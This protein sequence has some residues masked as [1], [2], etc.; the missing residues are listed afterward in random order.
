MDCIKI[1]D[2]WKNKIHKW[3]A[4][5]LEEERTSNYNALLEYNKVLAEDNLEALREYCKFSIPLLI[6]IAVV[7]CTVNGLKT[8]NIVPFAVALLGIM[9]I[10]RI[11][12]HDD[13]KISIVP[14]SYILSA[15]FNIIWYVVVICYDVILQP[16]SPAVLSCM[17]FAV[18]ALLYNAHPK[19][20]MIASMLAYC[21][22]LVLDYI[23]VPE[24]IFYFDAGNILIAIVIGNILNHKFTR[25]NLSQKL[26]LDMYRTASKTSI[27]VF[28]IDF[29]HDTYRMLQCP[30]YMISSLAKPLRINQAIEV[31]SAQFIAE[32]FRQDFEQ[33]VDLE[34]VS[35]RLNEQEQLSLYF[36]DFRKHW[37]QLT[38][39]VQKRFEG[40][41]AAIVAIVRDVDEEKRREFEYQRKLKETARAAEL[42]NSAKTNF[43]SR[44]THDIR[45][46]L[47]GIIGLLNI[48]EAHKDDI[49]LV[50]EN[51]KKMLV[52]A[53][54]LLSLINDMLEMSKLEDGNII[55]SHEVINLLELSQDMITIVEQRAVEAN[56]MLESFQ[57]MDDLP[58]Q[59]VYGSPL[60]IR[61]IFLNIY[62][63][64]IKYNKKGGK[65][66]TRFECLGVSD[67]IVTYQW[68]ISD[69]GIGMSREF[70][71]HIFEP[72]SQEH[73]DAR[74]V[75]QGTG[76]G[77]SI[78]KSLI[79]KMN[80]SIKIDSTEGEGSTFVISIPFET[81]QIKDS[82]PGQKS[83]ERTS[84]RGVHLLLAED[85]ELNAEIAET[86][87]RDEGAVVTIVNNGQKVID[88]FK[89]N[90]PGTYDAIL[91]DIMMPEVDGLTATKVIRAM[92]REDA[93]GIP[94][95][96]M[97]ANAFSEDATRCM[98]AGMNA[99][100][101]KPLQMDKV[102]A[103]IAKFR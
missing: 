91:M 100:L 86:L 33:F 61:Q 43:L 73:T 95:I 52:S 82:E 87:L 71:E 102:I 18:L 88:Q 97:T 36:M 84:I 26:Y 1:L 81:A 98:E 13:H 58:Y 51:R 103:T 37:C 8:I 59:Y 19:D 28:Q 62:G 75:Y 6:I 66:S 77:M 16:N 76:L 39:V 14:L 17:V 29:L 20:N 57:S 101:T 21:V 30:D 10:Q 96:A 22:M 42:A 45:T 50:C 47:N 15:L 7:R 2:K 99:H 70:L 12:R 23:R 38:L 48:N 60:H 27:L 55:L 72:F 92:D 41:I 46:P 68:T 56:I 49:Q 64:C 35:D 44:M 74:S 40:K 65:V 31:I 24:D 90:P 11:L 4:L 83:N 53:N 54:Y 78:V 80:G 25:L 85:N 34:T 89:N 32:E 94:I 67:N 5:G 93:P 79:D 63:N 3:F 9:Y 69:T